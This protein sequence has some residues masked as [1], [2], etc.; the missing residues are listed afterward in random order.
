ME[1]IREKIGESRRHIRIPV[2]FEVFSRDTGKLIGKAVNLSMNGM[3]IETESPLKPGTKLLLEFKLPDQVLPIKAYSDVKWIK[4]SPEVESKSSVMGLQFINIYEADRKKLEDYEEEQLKRINSDNLSLADFIDISDKDLFA[5]TRI[6]WEA[7]NDLTNKGFNMYGMPL[8]SA[9][10][11]RVLVLDKK[12]R[13]EKEVIMMSTSNYLDLASHPRVIDAA[14]KVIQKYGI[15]TGSVSLL[16]GTYDLHMKLESKLA[17]LKGCEDALIFPSGHMANMGGISALLGKKDVAIIDKMVHV[18]IL[19]G[20]MLSGGSFRTFRH[21]DPGH[22]RAVLEGVDSK[23]AGKLIIVEGVYGLDGDIVPLPEIIEIASEFEAK[24][25]IDDAHATGIIGNRGRGTASHFGMEG[26]VD[27]VMDSLSKALGGL[28]GYIAS[29]K[30]VI[31]YLKFYARPSMFSVSAPPVLVASALAAIQV[32]ESKP[33]LTERL[34]ENVKYMKENLTRIGFNN[35][36][37][38]ESA[39][40]STI[41]GNELT[42]RQMNRRIFEEGV[43]VEAISYPAVPRGQERLRLRIMSTHTKK[44]LDKTLE[45]LEKVGKE[46]NVLKNSG[47]V[48]SLEYERESRRS[49]IGKNEI[50]IAEASTRKGIAESVKFSWEV[51]KDYPEWVPYFLINDRINLLCGDYVYFR[52]NVKTKRFIAKENGKL[53]GAVS[54]FVDERFLRCWNQKVGFLG[55]FEALPGRDIAVGSL[56]DSAVDFLKSE[57]M[58]EVWAPINIPFPFYGGGLLSG[59]FDSV[60]TFLQPYNPPYYNKYFSDFGFCALKHLPHYSIDL[61][62]P[63]NVSRIYSIVRR[64]SVTVRELDKSEYDEEALTVLKIYNEAFPRLWRYATF[65][66]DEF[67]EFARDFRDLMIHG[68]WLIAETGGEPAGFIGAFPQCAQ[69]FRT[70]NGELGSPELFTI[71]DELERIKEGAIVL[72]GVLDKYTDREIG[73]ELIAHL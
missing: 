29:S 72:L 26:K 60:P 45:V 9:S 7:I 13:R 63:E 58:E 10:K 34:W 59:G 54:A 6:F 61:S 36:D 4:K 33:I 67:V 28:G 65:E 35:V 21:S 66:N 2:K 24:V 23:Y 48:V 12:T 68:L 49:I 38:S 52:N 39:I 14:K 15:G 50:E 32:M 55:F 16:S 62:S 8:L 64:S 43:Y 56:L 41:I 25:M 46:F 42:L 37:K 47:S 11:N 51:Y 17:E 71:P 69:I 44:D 73:L 31:N 3:L 19:D 5:K 30:E 22:L 20:C 70:I 1:L 57:G 40:I 53:V 18:S 27:I